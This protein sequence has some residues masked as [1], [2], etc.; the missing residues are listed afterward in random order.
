M[1]TKMGII[2]TGIVMLGIL[3]LT[4]QSAEGT[5]ALSN[6]VLDWFNKNGINITNSQLRG[7]VH[8]PLYFPLGFVLCL[9]F[10]YKTAISCGSLVGLSDEILK[11]FLPTRHF[12][13]MDV[14]SDIIGITLG[15]FVCFLFIKK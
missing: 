5:M 13:S 7:G 10:E 3:G 9:F 15:V 14:I 2:C 11:I 4:L 8:I 1:T 12:S 6:M